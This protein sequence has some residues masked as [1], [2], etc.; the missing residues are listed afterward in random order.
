MFVSESVD[1]GTVTAY[2]STGTPANLELRWA[3][4]D[5][6]AKGG[7][8][9]W[10]LFYQTDPTATGTQVAW[11]N[12][13]TDFKFN[14]GGQPS[15]AFGSIALNGV[16]INGVSLGNLTLVTP[17]GSITQFATT[18]GQTTVNTMQQNGYAAGKL[19]TIT[20]GNNGMISGTFTN[21]QTVDLAEIP[22]VHFNDAEQSS[23][24]GSAAPTR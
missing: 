15:P 20:V 13:G 19:Q 9:T 10:E 16:T 1:G 23:G 4:T 21:G 12:V 17:A 22:L 5:S 18:N 14:A 11:Q 2:D 3:K 8:D 6:V 7:T 24:S